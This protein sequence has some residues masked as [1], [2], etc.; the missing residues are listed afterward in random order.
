[1]TCHV[2]THEPLKAGCIRGVVG[3]LMTHEPLKAGRI[4]GVVGSLMS[5]R[6][7]ARMR[8]NRITSRMDGLS[9]RIITS[10]S[11]PIPSPAVGGS[12]YSSART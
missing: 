9:V 1:M 6:H 5:S 2:P 4:G 12:P 11:M 8:G 10:R 7:L 3:S